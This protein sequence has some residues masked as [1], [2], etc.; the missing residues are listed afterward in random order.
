MVEYLYIPVNSLNFN[1]ILSS[2]SI[3]PKS[4]YEKR[5]Y[6][7]KRFETLRVNPL[8]NSILAFNKI[9]DLDNIK[10]DR[11][12]FPLFVCVPLEYISS[13]SK[14]FE[15]QKVNV[16]RVDQSIYLN[17]IEC[18]FIVRSEQ[19]KKI[20][21]ANTLR[22]KEV[23]NSE[24]YCSKIYVLSS[25]S[26]D[27]V[28]WSDNIIDDIPDVKVSNR[29]AINR[30]QVINKFKGFLYGYLSGILSEYSPEIAE[31]SQLFKKFIN[32]YSANLNSL[33]VLSRGS[34]KK[35]A[36]YDFNA[37]NRSMEELRIVSQ[38]ICF[39]L[40]FDRDKMIDELIMDKFS[41]GLDKISEIRGIKDKDDLD[42]SWYSIIFNHYKSSLRVNLTI[43][44]YFDFIISDIERFLANPS[45]KAYESLEKNFEQYRSLISKEFDQMK[46]NSLVHN[47][48]VS[49]PF[50]FNENLELLNCDIEQLEP[51]ENEIY[52]KIINEFLSRFELST[53]D[54]I[55][56]ER[57]NIL[58]GI[59]KSIFR[60]KIEKEDHLKG[61]LNNLF[62]SLKRK[63]SGFDV[64]D[65]DYNT[66]KAL[67]FFLVR[68]SDIEKL[69]D[70]MEKNEFYNK[71]LVYGIWGASYGFANTSKILLDPIFRNE[72]IFS[73]MVDFINQKLFG[74]ELDPR[75]LEEFLDSNKISK[76]QPAPTKEFASK[77]KSEITSPSKSE[78]YGGKVLDKS[79]KI[80]KEE[81]ETYDLFSQTE[82]TPPKDAV[83]NSYEDETPVTVELNASDNKEESILRNAFFKDISSDG[84]FAKPEW[85]A[86][87]L[88]AL[89]RY[90][91]KVQK[92]KVELG[93]GTRKELFE[94]FLK[95][96]IKE[97][98]IA[99]SSSIRFGA[100]K[101]QKTI[102][103]FQKYLG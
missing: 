22:S 103:I 102:L 26:I 33:S 56:Q 100:K 40:G 48:K 4:F 68:F 64:N 27:K 31:S 35:K 98:N 67:A 61:Y 85:Q 38:N 49:I 95:E 55:A 59:G 11:E 39:I 29:D 12:E 90:E 7:F 97:R 71:S 6:G 54:E 18:F 42:V 36:Q 15:N 50:Q 23:K 70:Y 17:P 10:S 52:L 81:P 79:S 80:R 19:E 92:S 20:L 47:K 84:G 88:T 45:S 89:N 2:E 24:R 87:I 21:R 63:G 28:K 82:I 9:F 58:T 51:Q 44:D 25:L 96:C 72:N 37:I 41:V 86:V 94:N 14:S 83:S 75:L 16:F 62:R 60:K 78:N 101:I 53:S 66:I 74:R 13:Y 46:E 8:Q 43:E 93:I 76:T 1:N 65:T 99:E 32:I 69:T 91:T 57:Q 5:G 34:T 30:D 73:L 77:A 3:S